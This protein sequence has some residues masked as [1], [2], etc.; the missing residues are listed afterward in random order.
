[1]FQR[2]DI[3]TGTYFKSEELE[4]KGIKTSVFKEAGFIR[5]AMEAAKAIVTS[6][7]EP[8]LLVV[9]HDA[10]LFLVYAE[11]DNI[12]LHH[13]DY[14]YILDELSVLKQTAF[15]KE[16]I[17]DGEGYR[18]A[19]LRLQKQGFNIAYSYH[20]KPIVTNLCRNQLRSYPLHSV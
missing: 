15:L 1:M 12:A 2:V 7:G 16:K 4:E 11:D 10:S 14:S 8:E 9:T 5:K 18:P 6:C 20:I 19:L 13:A 17:A 3:E